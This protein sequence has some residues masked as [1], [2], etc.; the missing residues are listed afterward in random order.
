MPTVIGLF[1]DRAEAMHAYDALLSGGFRSADLDIL[2]NDDKDDVPKL[3]K[4]GDSVPEPDVHVYL[5]GVRQGSTLVTVNATG[6]NVTKAAEIM[7]GYHMVNISARVEEWSK[8]HRTLQLADPKTDENVLEVVEEELE[9]GTRQVERG[10]MRIYSK[11][12]EREVERQVSLRDETIRVRRRPVSREVPVSD[13]NLF[14]ERSY[15]MTEVDEEAVVNIRAR[16]IEE[17]VIDKEV[18]EKIETIHQTLRRT[19]VEIE[20]VP[21]VRSFD[22]YASDFRSYYTQRLAK[23]GLDY[24][25]YAPAFRFGHSLAMNEP[26]RSQ[27]WET[28]EPD[29]R[30]LWEEKN[31]G[32]WEQLKDAV[33]FS[34][35]KVRGAR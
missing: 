23:S 29:V 14:K 22:D 10:R 35:E 30:R 2:T 17:V 24:E 27:R 5:E 3:A 18:A 6:N 4:L 31:P 13:P 33:H 1:D 25:K 9:V 34:W 20:E 11:V 26:F 21:G 32:T 12:S 28:I 16:V 8:T 15:E 19:D 7:A